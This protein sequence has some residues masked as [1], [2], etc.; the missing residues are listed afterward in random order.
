MKVEKGRA[1]KAIEKLKKEDNFLMEYEIRRDENYVMI[2]VKHNVENEDHMIIESEPRELKVMPQGH[3]G[4][5]DLVGD[6]AIIHSRK[7]LDLDFM[8]GFITRSKGNIR[9]IYLDKGVKGEERLRD[10]ELLYGPDEPISMY[11][12]NNIVMKVDVK[13][14]YFSPRLSTERYLV[15]RNI[16]DNERIL[17]MFAGI[18]PFSLNIGK[19]KKCR[20]IA[21]DINP[22]A[23]ALLRYNISINRLQSEIEI[24][25]GDSYKLLKEREPFHRIIMNNPVNQYES[26][27]EVIG[28][29]KEGGRLNIYLVEDQESIEKYMEYFINK[30][31]ILESKRVVHG[32]SRNKSMYSLQY[33]RIVP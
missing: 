14:A 20:M 13:R 11:R 21:C 7:H 9:T 12:E 30:N 22:E 24:Y 3:A 23:V 1:Q 15:S 17:D 27:D 2:P 5:F 4:S 18:G 26:L 28:A 29:L 33:R 31:M 25:E 16:Q 10:L 32:Y 6:I 19:T 8:I